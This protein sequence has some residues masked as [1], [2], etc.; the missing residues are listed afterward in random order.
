MTLYLWPTL[1]FAQFPG[2]DGIATFTFMPTAPEVTH[3]V[4]AYHGAGDA[5]SGTEEK[6]LDY[7]QD[8]LGPED[9]SL[10]E[11]VQQGLHSLGYHQG[12]FMVDET[13]SAISE[14]AVHHF[15]NLVARA[16]GMV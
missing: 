12:R 1:A 16:L 8:V 5:L 15:Q 13:R 7:F 10:V 4:F 3:Q 6:S 2:T 9:V 11:D 14:H